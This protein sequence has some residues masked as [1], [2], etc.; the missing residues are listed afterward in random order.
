MGVTSLIWES[1][2]SVTSF[3]AIVTCASLMH[4]IPLVEVAVA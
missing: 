4:G 1:L 2:G 3:V